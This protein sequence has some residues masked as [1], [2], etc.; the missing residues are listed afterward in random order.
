MR[1]TALI[2]PESL[3][4]HFFVNPPSPPLGPGARPAARGGGRA[5]A[6]PRAE[7]H[8][9]TYT[10]VPSKTSSSPVRL[11]SFVPKRFQCGAIV[12]AH[13]P[14]CVS[15]WFSN[16]FHVFRWS[17][18]RVAGDGAGNR[19]SRSRWKYVPIPWG[20]LLGLLCK[21]SPGPAAPRREPSRAGPAAAGCLKPA[22]VAAKRGCQCKPFYTGTPFF[23][24]C[25]SS[26]SPGFLG[27][28]LVFNDSDPLSV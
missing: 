4:F 26:G 19:L 8:P 17:A 23:I 14:R 7:E 13:R 21:G 12:F 28:S 22:A 18:L 25:R 15:H 24:F 5:R 20:P 9:S 27:F 2:R 3:F 11:S 10:G 6:P 1:D 16:G